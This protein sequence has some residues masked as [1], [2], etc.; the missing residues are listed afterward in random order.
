MSSNLMAII[1]YTPP[2]SPMEFIKSVVERGASN[3][4]TSIEQTVASLF[5][6]IRINNNSNDYRSQTFRSCRL[7]YSYSL[8]RLDARKFSISLFQESSSSGVISLFQA[9]SSSRVSSSRKKLNGEEIAETLQN[10]ASFTIAIDKK[11][12]V[13]TYGCAFCVALGGY[14][15]TNKIAFMV[16]FSDAEEVI[17]SGDLI[18]F[19]IEK[20][21]K[22]KITTPIQLHLRGGIE[23]TS[24][25]IIEAIKIWMKQ[26]EDLPMEIASEDILCGS[27]DGKSLLID[28]RTGEVSDYDTKDNPKRR[29]ESELIESALQL[30]ITLAYSP[31]N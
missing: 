6:Y 13:A 14:D 20:L 4:S 7:F 29:G 5:S 16:H 17:E 12:I 22:E 25:P 27:L 10:E 11:P 9:S 26:R 1:P 23:G 21:V 2:K 18:F 8:D 3:G 28:S 30:Q 19:N 31:N 24:E 15:A